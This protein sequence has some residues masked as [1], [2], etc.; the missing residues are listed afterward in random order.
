[1][2][3]STRPSTGLIIGKFLPPHR[4]HLLLVDK[5]LERV[6]DLTILVCALRAEPIPGSVRLDWMQELCPRARVVLTTDE[7]PS[8]P[9]ES[10]DFWDLWIAT[11]RRALPHGP[12]LVFSSEDYGDELASRLGARHV[13]VDPLR[14]ERPVSGTAIRSDPLTHWD[15]LPEC[16]RPWFVRRVVL[17]GS[18]CTGKTTLAPLLAAH[19]QTTSVPEY[20]REYVDA[21]Q[22]PLTLADIELIARGQIASEERMARL[23]NRLLILD[24]DLISTA[25]YSRHYF[26]SAPEWLDRVIEQRRGMLYLLAGIDVPW[27]EDGAQRDRPH[28]RQEMQALFVDALRRRAIQPVLLNGGIEERLATAIAAIDQAIG[29]SEE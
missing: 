6:D 16:V 25:V 18:E 26:G 9:H 13:S 4:G 22:W 7:N 10:P 12:D 15:F 3:A 11:I 17:T 27:V 2:E 1:M 20:G 14:Q 23:A 19:Y 5:A 24:T 21:V 28:A 29:R 8:Y